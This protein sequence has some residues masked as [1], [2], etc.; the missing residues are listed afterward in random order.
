MHAIMVGLAIYIIDIVRDIYDSPFH[1]SFTSY[2]A[3]TYY[4][5]K[6]IDSKMPSDS[7]SEH[8]FFNKFLE[9]MPPAQ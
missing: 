4:I 8:L 9:F 2:I 1:I 5:A 7:I 6:Y 3:S